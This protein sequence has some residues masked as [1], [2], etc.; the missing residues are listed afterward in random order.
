MFLKPPRGPRGTAAWRI[1]IWTTLAF[2]FGSALA[3]WIVYLVVER[4]VR[5]RSDAW[6]SGEAETLAEVS[7]STPRGSLYDR[8]VEEVAELATNEVP[9]DRNARGQQPNSVFFLQTDVRTSDDAAIWVGPNSRAAFQKAI[10]QANLTPGTPE[11]IH[12]DG[13]PVSHFAW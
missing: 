10:Q 1:S 9:H 4:G 5:E 6:L 8:I 3:F 11:S 13:Y 2:A 12:V 7:Q